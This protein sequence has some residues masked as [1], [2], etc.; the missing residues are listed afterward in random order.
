MQFEALCNLIELASP[1]QLR[2]L[3][4]LVLKLQGYDESRITDGPHDGGSDLRL[5]SSVGK[6]LPLAIQTSV[7]KDWRKKLKADAA[8]IKAKLKL[9]RVQF[10]SS[11]R[12]PQA[13]FLKVQAELAASPG[14]TVTPVDQQAIAGLVED[15]H[16]LPEVLR[17][18]G[19]ETTHSLPNQ[20]ADRR[21]DAAFAYAFFAPEPRSFR[22]AIREQAMIQALSHA[23]GE[24]PVEEVCS[25]TAQL[26]GA[27]Q[28]AQRL[29]SV[30]DRLRQSGRIQGRNGTAV[31]PNEERER[32]AALRVLRENEESELRRQVSRLL[33]DARLTPHADAVEAVMTSLGALVLRDTGELHA[34]DLLQNKVRR[35]RGELRAY[36]LAQ[37]NK[38]E[39]LMQALVECARTSPLGRHLATGTLYQALISLDRDGL[40]R[41][42]D[43]RAVSLILDASVAIPMLCAHFHGSVKQRFFLVA[44]EMYRR[45]TE[46][47]FSLVLPE[48]WLE[49]MAAHLLMALDYRD[50]AG[51]DLQSLRMSKNAYVA[52]YANAL[53][54]P[55]S[56]D[57][58]AFLATFGLTP[59]IAN[60]ATVDFH[61]ARAQLESSLRRQISHYQIEITPIRYSPRRLQ[62]IQRQWEWTKHDLGEHG[63]AKILQQHDTQVLAWL[64]EKDP[65]D[66]PLVVTWDRLLKAM[67]PE[68]TLDPLAVCDLLSFVRGQSMPAEAL[69]YAS[70]LVTETDAERSANILDTLVR[71]EKDNLSDARLVQKMI[72]F[73]EGYLHTRLDASTVGEIQN[74]WQ[75]FRR[76]QD[77]AADGTD[78][79]DS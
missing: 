77:G 19:L 22:E 45:A 52:Y 55:S 24:A 46:L 58:M 18:F 12:I 2:A 75:A 8:T 47:G 23:G 48:A 11:R 70:L 66:A 42:L 69:R 63:R 25:H 73:K 7:E 71:L 5:L 68:A 65:R 9:D 34:L 4:R 74:E 38:T 33:M 64:A 54:A 43:A 30:F 78:S 36:G 50:L 57:L 32:L 41:A 37:G 3:A 44:E 21:K 31:L 1:Q 76:R 49:E 67:R 56:G 79:N 40:L 10:I 29:R 61:G 39:A 28:E 59:R 60:Q 20:P 62:D 13:T 15:H 14:V 51:A 16:A 53:S 17:I 72:E 35:L 27:P 26:L 6:E